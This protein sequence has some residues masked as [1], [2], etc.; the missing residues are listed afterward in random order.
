MTNTLQAANEGRSSRLL[1]HVVLLALSAV[2]IWALSV[3]FSEG[4]IVTHLTQHVPWGL[5]ISLYIYFIGLSAGSFL[6]STLIYV[7]GMKRFEAAGPLA[8]LQ[9]L[10]CLVLG[11][12]LIWIDLGHPARFLNVFAYWN[13]SSVLAWESALYLAYSVVI[14][15][16]L[17]LVLR[18]ALA[19]R[20][21]SG[22]PLAGLA[23]KLAFAGEAE[24]K[25]W[26]SKAARW[27]LLLGIIGIPIAIGVHGGTGAIFAVVKSRPTW[28]T[29]LFPIVFLV[30]ALASGGALLT[31][32]TAIS[33]RLPKAQKL[34]L[35]RS[36]GRLT[37]GVVALDLLLL[38]S[39]MLV[40]FY[41]G[42]PHHVAGW[43]QIMFG[44]FWWIFWFVQV[45]LGA[46]VPI[47][48]VLGK[49]TGN[50][51]GP[52]AI[53]GLLVVFGIIGVRLNIVVPA[54]IE[55]EFATLPDAYHHLRF[56]RGY[57][58]S[59]NEWLV[60]LG[61]VAIGTWLFFVARRLL[62]LDEAEQ[63]AGDHSTAAAGPPPIHAKAE[64]RPA[65][66]AGHVSSGGDL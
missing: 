22:G 64:G 54:Q 44:P 19:R 10:G 61:V 48:V 5:W 38:G 49:R 4:L 24:E 50:A 51:I 27:M 33:S 34:D 57:F 30:S 16:E 31:F 6:L 60:G 45:G 39:E 32:L 63:L 28:Y 47:L 59:G 52:L 8:L 11:M 36:L 46:V 13:Y 65:A 25:A 21:H 42:I 3:R 17:Y 40:V 20:A 53:A 1:G 26:R 9:A 14:I 55:P 56:V 66:A 23:K 15:A 7:F 18:P 41:G 12:L 43:H 58:P 2:G 37:V 35:V 29:G 62:P